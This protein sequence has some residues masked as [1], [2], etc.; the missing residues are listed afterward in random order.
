MSPH[1][2][3]PAAQCPPVQ[4]QWSRWAGSSLAP[5]TP[6]SV[7][8]RR[9]SGWRGAGWRVAALHP[10]EPPAAFLGLWGAAMTV[11]STFVPLSQPDSVHLQP[12]AYPTGTPKGSPIGLQT[13]NLA[14]QVS[15]CN[16]TSLIWPPLANSPM[17]TQCKTHSPSWRESNLIHFWYKIKQTQH[18]LQISRDF[19]PMGL[20]YVLKGVL[21]FKRKL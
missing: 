3:F 6:G 5:C 15:G 20:H 4:G 17:M 13:P 2:P 10:P 16:H 1:L 14:Y 18:C 19:S 12:T 7:L 11:V 21:T 8:Q 9:G